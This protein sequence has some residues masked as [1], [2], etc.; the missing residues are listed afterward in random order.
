MYSIK[1]E[2]FKK[3]NDVLIAIRHLASDSPVADLLD[4]MQRNHGGH[5][6]D[7]FDERYELMEW[8]N[9]YV[10]WSPIMEELFHNSYVSQTMIDLLKVLELSSDWHG[11]NHRNN[12]YKSLVHK[13]KHFLDY[14]KSGAY[15]S[16]QVEAESTIFNAR[17]KYFNMLV[18][19]GWQK[20]LEAIISKPHSTVKDDEIMKDIYMAVGDVAGPPFTMGVEWSANYAHYGV[21]SSITLKQVGSVPKWTLHVDFDNT[22][23]QSNGVYKSGNCMM[24]LYGGKMHYVDSD[25]ASLYLTLAA[26]RFMLNNDIPWIDRKAANLILQTTKGAVQ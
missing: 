7:G 1:N 20:S 12:N 2:D 25:R 21:I 14:K 11:V 17:Q 16:K 22:N 8:C 9:H 10:D 24:R 23:F 19:R 5:K 26:I 3:F 13:F 6:G 4:D 18:P 15:K